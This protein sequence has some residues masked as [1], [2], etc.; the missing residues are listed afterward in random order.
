MNWLNPNLTLREYGLCVLTGVLLAA[1]FPPWNFPWHFAFVL[2]PL[3]S[4]TKP[5]AS[6]LNFWVGFLSG[7]AF[8]LPLL[9]WLFH[10]TLPGMILLVIF[11]SLLFS[12]PFIVYGLLPERW[13][14]PLVFG[15]VW[16]LLE[17][18]RSL[19][20][21][22][23]AWG[24]MGHALYS[25]PSLIGMT[26]LIGVPGLSG[27]IA[28]LNAVCFDAAMNVYRRKI[29]WTAGL[30]E[31]CS[32]AMV[33]LLVFGFSRLNESTSTDSINVKIALLQGNFSMEIKDQRDD[34]EAI[35][36]YLNLAEQAMQDKPD[37][38]ILPESSIGVPLNFSPEL[39]DRFSHF[40]NQHNVEML[41]GGVH[42][43]YHGQG[44][45]DFW[46]R[47][48]LFSPGQSFD[49]S[50]DPVDMSG[51]QTYDKMHLVPYGEWVPGGEYFIFSWIETL[52]EEAGA[53]IFQRGKKQTIFQ[54]RNGIRF[55]VGICFESTLANQMS[56]AKKNGAQFLVN[57]TN[58][59]W[60]KRSP[61]LEQHFL[62]SVFRAAE[63]QCY[64]VRAANTGITA[65]I[66]PNGS[67][68]KRIPD[69][70]TGFC[71]DTITLNR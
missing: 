31:C 60:F 25:I 29:D 14:R 15:V 71:V 58:D 47:A 52:I 64:V 56:Q 17:Y 65:I 32:I 46:N 23:F 70:E 53:G 3:L 48:Y 57:I 28:A 59:A 63:N 27:L 51:M 4:M 20:S 12:I 34:R 2:F 66:N 43:L 62:Q 5:Q 40:V 8:H 19:G 54:L 36:V 9:Y 21:F 61:G 42:G 45:W 69:N 67:I 50:V 24:G 10:A 55:A 7:L 33:I 35:D 16:A 6:R 22:S 38:I 39:V 26:T 18:F 41:V 44:R 13:F 68:Q 49:T 30:L 37:L 11:I 1:G